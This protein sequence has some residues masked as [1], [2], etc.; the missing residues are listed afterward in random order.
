LAGIARSGHALLLL[1]GLRTVP[2]YILQTPRDGAVRF[3]DQ[4]HS[5]QSSMVICFDFGRLGEGCA[6]ERLSNEKMAR[7][8][9]RSALCQ[10]MEKYEPVH[11]R[12]PK[13]RVSRR[14]EG[15][16]SGTKQNGSCST[17]KLSPISR[18]ALSVRLR[19]AHSAIW[20]V[21][22]NVRMIWSFQEAGF[23][24]QNSLVCL[25]FNSSRS[26]GNDRAKP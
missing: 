12:F 4:E 13:K 24:E 22:R 16:S 2:P 14:D 20:L 8:R 5:A 6:S 10:R 1:G 21:V 17:A 19:S 23:H 18:K 3:R 9:H 11:I 26:V 7:T 15:T 25:W